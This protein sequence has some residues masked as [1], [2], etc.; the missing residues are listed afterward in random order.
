[1]RC[2]IIQTNNISYIIRIVFF[3]YC[4][5]EI[6]IW[7]PVFAHRESIMNLKSIGHWFD[8]WAYFLHNRIVSL[9]LRTFFICSS[10]S[11]NSNKRLQLKHRDLAQIKCKYIMHVGQ[12]IVNGSTL[13]SYNGDI[14][15]WS[16]W[17]NPTF[18][19]VRITI[20]ESNCNL[21]V[22]VDINHVG[23][24]V[25]D[26]ELMNNGQL[27]RKANQPKVD[28]PKRL[29]SAWTLISHK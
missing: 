4:G 29:K 15:V 21:S 14:F 6:P 20:I 13:W 12:S 1:M 10:Y 9:E 3:L 18:A 22:N 11:W 25:I 7:H 28:Q 19:K 2:L 24:L 27:P 8:Y 17:E 26:V 5:T 23:L 16:S